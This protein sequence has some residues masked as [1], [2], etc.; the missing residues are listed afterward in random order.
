MISKSAKEEILSNMIDLGIMFVGK[1]PD[2]RKSPF[3]TEKAIV[4]ELPFAK[5]DF[6][7]VQLLH[8]WINRNYNLI[9]AELLN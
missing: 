2:F 6:L 8:S 5:E 9:H 7:V 4:A 1:R 3:T